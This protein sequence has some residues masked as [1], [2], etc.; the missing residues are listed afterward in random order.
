[1]EVVGVQPSR[2]KV[3]RRKARRQLWGEP[4]GRSKAPYPLAPEGSGDEMVAKSMN[5]TH[6][7][8]RAPCGR[9]R[10]T[11]LRG[12]LLWK[13]LWTAVRALYGSSAVGRGLPT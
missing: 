8:C 10:G 11:N 1:V 7:L 4:A 9:R 13:E 5:L 2:T 6:E 12:D 3:K